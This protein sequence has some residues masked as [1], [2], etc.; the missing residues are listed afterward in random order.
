MR[1][2]DEPTAGGDPFVPE[3]NW[4]DRRCERCELT[5]TCAL[6]RRERGQQWSMRQRRIDPDS[7]EGFATLLLESLAS[8]ERMLE[9]IAAEE[10]VDLRS[11]MSERP[12]TFTQKRLMRAALDVVRAE[13]ADVDGIAALIVMK[14]ARVGGYIEN[15]DLT[16]VDVNDEESVWRRDGGPNLF[17]IEHLIRSLAA[18]LAATKRLEALRALACLEVLLKPLLARVEPLRPFLS[19]R[20]ASR[21]APSPFVMAPERAT[22]D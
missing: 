7:D 1:D 16:S 3:H 14:I 6:A 22:K 13:G 10:G 18:N 15:D 12:P 9:R 21:T 5:D 8:A 17:L 19:A 4:C 2:D 20:L 11:V